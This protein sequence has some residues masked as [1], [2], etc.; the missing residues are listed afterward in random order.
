MKI[1][2]F[3][4]L[5]ASCAWAR[6]SVLHTAASRAPVRANPLEGDARAERAGAKIFAHECAAC[7][8]VGGIGGK[9]APRLQRR[10][11]YEAPP[12]AL[13]WVLRNG[14]LWRGMPSFAALPEPQRWQIIAYLQRQRGQETGG[15]IK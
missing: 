12:A 5:A 9:N 8:G 13:F 6:E 3:C 1:V 4:L 14:S 11:V 7:H 15:A 10:D 2:L